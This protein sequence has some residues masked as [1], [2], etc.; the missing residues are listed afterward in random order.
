MNYKAIFLLVI[1]AIFVF[2]FIL[3]D[4]KYRAGNKPVKEE[5]KD[6]YDSE[7]YI[8][9][10]KY[11]KEK[12]VFT[13]IKLYV[14]T[15][16]II[17]LFAFKFFQFISRS[18]DSN[19]AIQ[20][21]VIIAIYLVI[22]LIIDVSF[23]L[24]EDFVIEARYG[25]NKITKKTFISDTIISFLLTAIISYAAIYGYVLIYRQ[26]GIYTIPTCIAILIVIFALFSYLFPYFAKIFNKFTPLADGELKNKL[27]SL[28][29]KEG[30]KIKGIYVIDASKRSTK[31][32]AYCA[33][34]GNTKKIVIYD[35]LLANFT[36][37][38][39]VAIFAH[40]LGHA[41]HKDILKN[42]PF[43]ILEAI[44]MVCYMYLITFSSDIY[45]SFKFQA[46]NYGFA[47]ILFSETFEAFSILLS[48][49]G[50]Y[51]SR[52]AE[53]AADNNAVKLGYG[54]SLISA[55]KKITR[56][57]FGNLSTSKFYQIVRGNHPTLV[58][59]IENIK[60]KEKELS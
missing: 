34:I 15:I 56:E 57:N 5:V 6:V 16:I 8:K 11:S 20:T 38:E 21:A 9:W 58:E 32:N 18:L 33:G 47:F 4:L 36:D 44:I 51:F 25:F 19:W 26:L 52:K 31:S 43:T 7:T 13:L 2:N 50:N 22:D 40:E 42:I 39:I 24:Y 12:T 27:I 60:K 3:V 49:L 10:Q 30:Y 59:R 28:M 17:F 45:I 54:D 48:L 14:H 41:L 23:S 1:T 55:L 37:D 29:D 46:I 35:T 53:Y